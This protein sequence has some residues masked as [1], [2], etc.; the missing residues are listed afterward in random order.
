MAINKYD[1]TQVQKNIWLVDKFEGN[2]PINNI[3]G[4][5]YMSVPAN[6][7][8]MKQTI[9]KIVMRH[10]ALRLRLYEKN[11]KVY[12]STKP[13]K[14]FEIEVLDFTNKKNKDVIAWEKKDATTPISLYDDNLFKFCI[15]K[16]PNG[17][18]GFY[19]KLHHIISDAW[20]MGLVINDLT[21]IY[22][23]LLNGN[24]VSFEAPSYIDYI[25]SEKEYLESEKF[26]KDKEFWKDYLKDCPNP[27]SISNKNISS[28]SKAKRYSVKLDSK[29]TNRI[30]EFCKKNK[31]SPYILFMSSISTYIHRIKG[32][33]DFVLGTPVL[34]RSNFKE[35]NCAGMFISTMPVRIKIYENASFIDTCKKYGSEHMSLFRH[36]KYPYS[37]TLEDM[38]KNTDIKGNLYNVMFSY[39]NMRPDTDNIGF[40]TDTKWIFSEHQRDQLAIHV[41]DINNAGSYQINYDYLVDMFEEIDMEY[42]NSRLMAIIDDAICNPNKK[43]CDIEIMSA[44]EKD[45]IINKFNDTDADYPRDKTIHEI[46]DYYANKTPNKKAII[47]KDQY[48]TYSQLKNKSNS[49]ASK[50]RMLG[51]KPNETIV[52][53]MDKCI[54]LMIGILG[55]LKSSAA[56]LPID[57]DLPKDRINYMIENS[58]AKYIITKR[59]I[60]CSQYGVPVINI[61]L[62]EDL[63]NHDVKKIP[64]LNSPDDLSYVMYTSGTT[65]KPKGAMMTHRNVIK[66]SCKISY[67]DIKQVKNVFISGSIV[68]DASMYEMWIGFL[69]NKTCILVDKLDVINPKDYIKLLRKF[70][71]SFLVFTTQL[72]H[73]YSKYSKEAFKNVLY[74]I[75]GRR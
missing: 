13:F 38:H 69:N 62:S 4:S 55:I 65:G 34:N 7:E 60:D 66:L 33:D 44:E 46:F 21:H 14:D 64:N 49:L 70:K 63:Y 53:M 59:E 43:I 52:I 26:L 67:L 42:L 48:L 9:N 19:V 23:E 24:D 6:V 72:F 17:N 8:L 20:T 12:Q 5:M 39:Q 16:L 35:K 61:G 15:L 56:Y 51:I 54:E 71:K 40:E 30:N 1:L 50:I 41:T 31:I 3:A 37:M 11:D 2:S 27:V 57:S 28:S 25:S 74:V 22:S 29:Q 45:L 58:N 32:V 10:E 68:F 75:A 36:Q 73:Q 18:G 47:Y